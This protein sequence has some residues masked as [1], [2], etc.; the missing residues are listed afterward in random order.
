M[1]CRNNRVNDADRIHYEISIKLI[2]G[3]GGAILASAL[4][5]AGGQAGE[6]AL[7]NMRL[8]FHGAPVNNFLARGLAG[9]V[10]IDRNNVA[11]RAQ[12][13]DFVHYVLGL[14]TPN[15]FRLGASILMTPT[16]FMGPGTSQHTLPCGGPGAVC[17]P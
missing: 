2:R 9:S 7:S 17:A 11:I 13:A 5:Y 1:D 8:A 4:R 14:N 10:G 12:G 15:P 6:N 16:L 3:Q